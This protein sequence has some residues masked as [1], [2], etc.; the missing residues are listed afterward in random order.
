VFLQEGGY[1]AGVQGGILHHED[2][3]AF[4]VTIAQAFIFSG[5]MDSFFV[6]DRPSPA[7]GKAIWNR[8]PLVVSHTSILPPMAVTM[9]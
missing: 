9:P 1:L 5:R 4:S 6:F 7:T 8:A 3:D 2:V